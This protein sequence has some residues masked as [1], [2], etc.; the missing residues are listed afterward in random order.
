MN[1]HGNVPPPQRVTALLALANQGDVESLNALF[2]TLYGEL[3]ALARA[4]LRRSAPITV[5]D[6]TSLLHE[7]YLKLV[8]SGALNIENRI[9]FL[10]YASRTM[11]SIIVDFARRRLADRRGSGAEHLPID[12]NVSDRAAPSGE[13]EI[14]RVHDALEELAQ[15]EPRL[16]RVVEM[17]Y[18]GGMDE[19]EI[20]QVLGVTDRTV[21]RDWH[22]A[23][24]ILSLALA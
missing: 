18:Y 7:S 13:E 2:E 21:R 8:K 15:S 19:T 23:R 4:R 14:V 11:R 1:D 10:A 16:A 3:H 12:T 20:A 5:L 17:R 6:T 9:H 22:K 24:L